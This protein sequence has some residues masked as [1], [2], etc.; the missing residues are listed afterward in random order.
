MKQIGE[1]GKALSVN[2]KSTNM[3]EVSGWLAVKKNEILQIYGDAHSFALAF[4]PTVQI[5]CAMNIERSLTADVPTIRQLLYTYKIEHLQIWMMAQIEDL[6][7]YA[8]VKN[9][10]ATKQMKELA[11]IIIVKS[12]YLKASEILLF[13][14]KL[15]AG[16][17]GG[18]YG[19]VDPQKVGEYLNA[20]LNWR[21]QELDKVYSKQ[22][23]EERD[24]KRKEWETTGI[25]REEFEKLKIS[26]SSRTQ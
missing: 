2:K 26:L 10:M 7:E 3:P 25:T 11:S 8:G 13:F 21:S 6:N 18:F 5:K 4:N 14:Y 20:F 1:I 17:F 19:T 12:D 24:R 9:K 16:D 23:Q 15:K 22:A